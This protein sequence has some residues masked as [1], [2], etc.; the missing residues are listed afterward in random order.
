MK[1]VDLLTFFET[2]L[3]L[4]SSFPLSRSLTPSL[5][6]SHSLVRDLSLPRSRPLT[7][8]FANSK[9]SRSIPRS[10]AHSLVLSLLTANESVL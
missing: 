5:A 6:I 3:S 7:P 8:S 4:S 9:L 1:K 2:V 10:L